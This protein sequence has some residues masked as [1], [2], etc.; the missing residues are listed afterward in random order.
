MTELEDG[1]RGFGLQ[2]NGSSLPIHWGGGEGEMA[3]FGFHARFD[4]SI[5][6]SWEFQVGRFHRYARFMLMRR[7]H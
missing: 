7:L 6:K 3:A 1:S 2:M 5:L 4:Q